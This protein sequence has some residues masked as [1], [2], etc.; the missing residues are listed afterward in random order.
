MGVHQAGKAASIWLSLQLW[1]QA[2]TEVASPLGCR[3]QHIEFTSCATLAR[4]K[5]R[6]GV[7]R[8]FIS[9]SS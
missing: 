8:D 5:Q 3:W 7:S 6:V 2:A 4:A 9:F 1:H